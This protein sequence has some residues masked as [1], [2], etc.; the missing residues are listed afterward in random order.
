[1]DH[2]Q[3]TIDTDKLKD[4]FASDEGMAA[5]VEQVLNQVLD[6]HMTGH[7]QAKPYERTDRR[8][9]Y[10]NG[11]KPRQLTTRVGTLRLRVPQARDGSF[12]TDLFRRYQ[13]AQK[14]LRGKQA[15]VLAMM[16]MVNVDLMRSTRGVSTR[17]VTKITEELC[18]ADYELP[19]WPNGSPRRS[20]AASG[21]PGSFQTAHRRTGWSE[22]C[23][24]SSMRNGTPGENTS[25]WPST[26][27]GDRPAGH[28]TARLPLSN[29]SHNVALN[30]DDIADCFLQQNWGLI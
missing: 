13:H 25:T 10:R 24:K 28:Q 17:K 18:G 30:T 2:L 12:S 20:A 29:T 4:L 3:V 5:L 21:C 16:E 9:A 6:A 8:R 7:L 11:Y 22:R 14:F 1:M 27:N 15:L 23:F 26:S 19:I